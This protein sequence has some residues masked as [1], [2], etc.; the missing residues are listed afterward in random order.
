MI[1]RAVTSQGMGASQGASITWGISTTWQSGGTT[2]DLFKR[3]SLIMFL[4]VPFSTTSE[5]FSI[6]GLGSLFVSS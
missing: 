1:Y 6:Y 2:A 5:A 4:N 3:V